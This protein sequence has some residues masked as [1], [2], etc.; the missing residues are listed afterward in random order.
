MI[1]NNTSTKH[2]THLSTVVDRY[3]V[4]VLP[5]FGTL[6][7]GKRLSEK[8]FT[9]LRNLA[10]LG[11]NVAIFSNVP[12]RRHVLI[13]DLANIGI[14][15]SLYQHVITSGEEVFHALKDRKDAFHSSLGKKCYVIG[16]SQSLSLLEGLNLS[17]VT[18]IDEADFILALAPTN[19]TVILNIISPL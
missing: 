4:F 10:G 14:P 7:N 5:V 16:S 18:F 15:P 8:A 19:G 1:H 3:S 2:I 11:K 17:R 12:K 9:C 13:Q 6:H